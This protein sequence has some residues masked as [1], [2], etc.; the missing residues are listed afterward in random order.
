MSPTATAKRPASKT[1]RPAPAAT[2][3]AGASAKLP[4]GYTGRLLRV[5]LTTGKCWA[6]PWSPDDMREYLGGVG[7][8]AKILY[9]EVGPK[10]QLGSS[11]QPS[12][13]GHRA[14]GRAAGVGHGR[15]HRDHARRAHQRR[16]LHAG[17]RLLRRRAQVL[18]LRRDH[19]PGAGQ[20]A[21]LPLHQRRRDRGA[22]RRPPGRQGHL[23]DAAGARGRARALRPPA[24][25]VLHRPRRR[26]RA[27]ASRPSTATTATW[28]R[29]TAAA[30][31]WARRSSRRCAS[32]AAPRRSRPTIPAGVVQAADDIAHD[33]KTDPS[34][35]TLYHLG[36]LP[37]VFNLSQAG[38]AADQE[39]HDQ[40]HR[41]V[42]MTE[43]EGPKLREGFD[44]RGHQ[45][46]ACG[47][48]HCH[49]QVIGEGPNE[50]E[51][52]DEPEYEGW[53]GAGWTMRPHRQGG[54]SPGSTRAST[55]P[56]WTSTSSAGCAAG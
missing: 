31:S 42:D 27:C 1:A 36:T 3:P 10:A 49:I 18:R 19:H 40:P 53:S 56:A 7:L 51:R 11:R 13:P 24:L 38:R 22:R 34:T 9:E 35:S 16:H 28:R 23:G 48:R 25:R 5:N 2:K 30:P 26:E 39:L 20:E 17:Q 14:A 33:L 8:G 15:P 4:G 44:H 29:R 47:M 54:Q 21:V 55:G 6:E 43:W 52:V 12:R 50:G 37:G 32:C 46:N 41:H 45:C